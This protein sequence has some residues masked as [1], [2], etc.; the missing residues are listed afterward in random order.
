M[1]SSMY[2]HSFCCTTC[3][4]QW[5]E[6]YLVACISHYIV[7]PTRLCDPCT[8]TLPGM[9]DQRHCDQVLYVRESKLYSTVTTLSVLQ[10]DK[11]RLLLLSL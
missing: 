2:L 7:D 9:C 6:G 3:F 1:Y 10:G 8:C 11:Q 4:V 5:V